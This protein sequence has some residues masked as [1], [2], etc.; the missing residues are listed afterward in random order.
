VMKGDELARNIKQMAPAEP[1]LMITGSAGEFG[2]KEMSVDAIL[3]KPF[4][5]DDLREAV[6]QLLSPVPA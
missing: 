2:G 5:F 3:N 4:G 1:I 6:A